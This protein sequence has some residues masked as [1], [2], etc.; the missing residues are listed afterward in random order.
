MRLC[1]CRE[2]L[3]LAGSRR[4][5]F[6]N[7]KPLNGG[8]T[9]QW[10]HTDSIANSTTGTTAPEAPPNFCLFKFPELSQPI[11]QCFDSEQY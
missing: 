6:A 1:L 8:A 10:A 2:V 4:T 11:C 5:G 9:G 7:G 3:P